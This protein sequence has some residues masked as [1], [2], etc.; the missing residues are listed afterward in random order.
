M[1]IPA[2]NYSTTSVA[3]SKK[4]DI[5]PPDPVGGS[6]GDSEPPVGEVVFRGSIFVEGATNTT[7]Q[8]VRSFGDVNVQGELGDRVVLIAQPAVPL[9]A[10]TVDNALFA[11]FAA[12]AGDS[13]LLTG[14]PPSTGAGA[15]T[16]V[17]RDAL[18][19]VTA[20]E[21]FGTFAGTDL[22]TASI[23][24][25]N[26]SLVQLHASVDA[27]ASRIALNTASIVNI[28]ASLVNLHASVDANASLISLNIASIVNINA[29]LVQL[30]AS[31]D[32]N[33]SRI[34]LNTASIVNIN[35]SLVQINNLASNQASEITVLEGARASNAPL[36]LDNASAIIVLESARA[37]NAP[38]ILDNASAI[39]ALETLTVSHTASLASAATIYLDN[40]SAITVLEAS[41]LFSLTNASSGGA[42]I[43]IGASNNTGRLRTLIGGS[44]VE[45]TQNASSITITA[46][47]NLGT[48]QASITANES[49][50]TALEG[51]GFI[52]NVI[53][54]TTPELGGNLGTRGFQIVNASLISMSSTGSILIAADKQIHITASDNI[55]ITGSVVTINGIDPVVLDAGHAS[56]AA[57][58]LDNASAITVLE[59]A[60]ASN[61]PLILD[62]ASAIGALE[63]LTVSHTASLASA[64][65]I[66]LDN[67][68]AITVLE[69]ARA[70][71]APLIVDNASAIGALETLTVA[72]T[73]SLASA[74]TIYLDNASAIT[75]LE[76]SALFSL[77][78]ASSGDAG[79]AIGASNNT[80]R[81]RTL[82]GGS[83][84]ELT[85]NA[86]SITI[87]A[88]GNLGTLQASVTANETAI[89]DNATAITALQ[90]STT[91]IDASIININAS[92]VQLHASVDALDLRTLGVSNLPVVASTIT[93]NLNAEPVGSVH[94]TLAST[95][96]N[97]SDLE[98]G[99]RYSLIVTQASNGTSL[100]FNS[101]AFVG[102]P[103]SAD[104]PDI[105]NI[106]ASATT[107]HFISNGSHLFTT[108]VTDSSGDSYATIFRGEATSARYA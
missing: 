38:L 6:L 44:G 47:G 78:N 7:R 16:I 92:L 19:D 85:Q 2:D 80:G 13:A 32:A 83:G 57:I 41:A 60:R 95:L 35:A 24:N 46:S 56:T 8:R 39:G 91:R 1:A 93:W 99:R 106:G 43:A 82:M 42:V 17:C 90:A 21:F 3:Y 100:T 94:L 10:S 40:A 102:V 37:S 61:A 79:I 12:S 65:T 4:D 101:S 89:A 54:D 9:S 74:A 105:L 14:K 18:G 67:A 45:L 26:A 33:A 51:R 98:S 23:I 63:T 68:S 104:V 84:I 87:A 77:T 29:S 73:G 97:I 36:I 108:A 49:D 50:I 103:S 5:N 86:S 76:A 48:L 107:F 52:S 88:S 66:Y 75:V 58:A 53:Q 30:H 69:G 71:N 55:D 34:V 72:H 70:S 31:V 25:I 96:I 20:N 59:G 64:A 11:E 27:N 15:S 81:L 62:N 22:N 28:N